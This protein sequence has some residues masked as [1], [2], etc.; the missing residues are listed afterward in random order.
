MSN[1]KIRTVGQVCFV[2]EDIAF[3]ESMAQSYVGRHVVVTFSSPLKALER[4]LADNKLLVDRELILERIFT[5][6]N[7]ALRFSQAIHWLFDDARHQVIE[8]IFAYGGMQQMPGGEL[9]RRLRPSRMRRILLTESTA[10]EDAVQAFNQGAIDIFVPKSAIDL[11]RVTSLLSERGPRVALDLLWRNLDPQINE[12]LFRADVHAQIEQLMQSQL[13]TE[14]LLLPS[15]AGFV[16]RTVD[17]RCLWFQLE[18]HETQVGAV[19]ILREVGWD[20]AH[21]EDVISGEMAACLEALP[22]TNGP[23]GAPEYKLAPLV[24]LVD[25]PWLGLAIFDLP[26]PEFSLV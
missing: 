23:G 13:V 24:T 19:E 25:E 18:T 7:V 1:L 15:P 10:V 22:Y 2:D 4:L 9:F 6:E 20:Q 3:L 5:E 12:A 11:P 8:T 21:L 16:C 17:N 14:Y 26:M